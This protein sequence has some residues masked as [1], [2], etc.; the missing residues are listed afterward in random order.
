VRFGAGPI[1]AAVIAM[2]A[3]AAGRG[4]HATAS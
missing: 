4:D 2:G 1:A 3:V